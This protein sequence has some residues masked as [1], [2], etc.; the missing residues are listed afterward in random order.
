MEP[1]AKH[2]KEND[3]EI[4]KFRMEINKIETKLVD[5]IHK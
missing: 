1:K 2:N 4:M 5:K 3:Q